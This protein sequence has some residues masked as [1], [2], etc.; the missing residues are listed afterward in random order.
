LDPAINID[1][2]VLALEVQK[3]HASLALYLVQSFL[4]EM[5][6]GSLLIEKIQGGVEQFPWTGSF[7]YIS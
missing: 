7:Y 1:P 6:L 3:S 2:S 5:G 4:E